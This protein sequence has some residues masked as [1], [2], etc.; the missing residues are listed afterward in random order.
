MDSVP[1]HGSYEGTKLYE[2]EQRVIALEK[3][4]RLLMH[5]AGREI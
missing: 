5:E 2:I 1:S 4:V 3:A